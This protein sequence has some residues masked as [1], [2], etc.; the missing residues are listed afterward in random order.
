MPRLSHW[1]MPAVRFA[2]NLLDALRAAMPRGHCRDR[3]DRA[4]EQEIIRLAAQEVLGLSRDVLEL[5]RARSDH[6][7]ALSD[8]RYGRRSAEEREMALLGFAS[9]PGPAPDGQDRA[10]A[11]S[12]R[13]SRGA[14]QDLV[15]LSREALGLSQDVLAEVRKHG[16]ADRRTAKER[17]MEL[18]GF[19]PRP[20]P[21][22][23]GRYRAE[24][25]PRTGA[26]TRRRRP[27]EMQRLGFEIAR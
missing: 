21:N 23:G 6:P 2:G 14:E 8:R 7:T 22:P 5:T 11:R 24:A 12:S 9:H 4:A 17:E 20:R 19:V 26:T 15:R 3:V 18:L 13:L 25:E 10:E 1:M 27:R 16:P